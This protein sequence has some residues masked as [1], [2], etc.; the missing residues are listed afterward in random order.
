[1]RDRMSEIFGHPVTA[2]S[3]A[4]RFN[5]T[6]PRNDELWEREFYPH[7]RAQRM[8]VAI[9]ATMFYGISGYDL[10]MFTV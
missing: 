6:W 1:M 10:A 4:P 2:A 9:F 7:F 8:L 5:T 3:R